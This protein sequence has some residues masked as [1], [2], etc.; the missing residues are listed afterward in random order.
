MDIDSSN[1]EQKLEAVVGVIEDTQHE[2]SNFFLGPPVGP[3][4]KFCREVPV[5]CFQQVLHALDRILPATR[6]QYIL[7]APLLPHLRCHAYHLPV[8]YIS[9]LESKVILEEGDNSAFECGRE[10][11]GWGD[12]VEGISKNQGGLAG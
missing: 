10:R 12:V 9:Q 1:L 7:L 4:L 3:P 6:V 2:G 8:H 5:V 11:R